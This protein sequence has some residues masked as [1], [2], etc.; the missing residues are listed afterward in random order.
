[1]IH[2]HFA[3]EMLPYEFFYSICL[4]VT[5]VNCHLVCTPVIGLHRYSSRCLFIFSFPAFVLFVFVLVLLCSFCVATV[6]R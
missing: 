2:T 3:F 1:M 4:T 6:L 5:I